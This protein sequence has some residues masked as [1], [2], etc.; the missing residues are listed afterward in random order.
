VYRAIVRRRMGDLFERLNDGDFEALLRGVRDDVHH[1]F[2]GE[3]AL[4]GERHSREAMRRWFERLGRIFPR[5]RMEVQDVAVRGW[6][7]GTTVAIQWVNRAEPAD[8]G[9]YYNEGVH[10]VRLRW[11]KATDIHAYLDTEKVTEVCE[12]LAAGGLE[13]AVAPPITG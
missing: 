2:P 5:H 13:E 7:W 6:P 3:N 10:V 8:G 9:A 12:R 1:V 4:G 11:G